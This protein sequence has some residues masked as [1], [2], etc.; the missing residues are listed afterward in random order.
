M[1]QRTA[2]AETL[3]A[4][5]RFGAAHSICCVRGKSENKPPEGYWGIAY[6]T[7]CGAACLLSESGMLSRTSIWAPGSPETGANEDPASD[8]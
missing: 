3:P 8:Q 5:L 4:C 7:F 1:V 6:I 2:D